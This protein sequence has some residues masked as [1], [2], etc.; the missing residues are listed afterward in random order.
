MKKIPSLLIIVFI[1]SQITV[2][3]QQV[4][5]LNH[6]PPNATSVYEINIPVLTSKVSWQEIIKHFP[7]KKHDAESEEMMQLLS[8]PSLAGIDMN[9]DIIIAKSGNVLF[10]SVT[11]TIIIGYIN[12]AEK[13]SEAIMKVKPASKIIVIPNKYRQL[14]D[15][16]SGM[17]WNDKIFVVVTVQPVWNGRNPFSDSSTMK[18]GGHQKK[19]T[20]IQ[21]DVQAI[22]YSILASKKSIAVFKGFE[23]SFFADD[24][25]FRTDFTNNADVHIWTEQPN[26]LALMKKMNSSNVFSMMQQMN[27]SAGKHS[28]KILVSIRFDNGMIKMDSK[29]IA[30]PM[31]SIYQKLVGRPMSMDL[32]HKIPGEQVIGFFSISFDPTFIIDMLGNGDRRKKIDST[33]DS[34]NLKLDDIVGAFKGDF[35][36][37]AMQPADTDSLH[38]IRI[39]F[40][41][42][43]NDQQS[44]NKLIEELK[45]PSDNKK[46]ENLFSKMKASYNAK[47]NILGLSGNQQMADAFVNNELTNTTT[48]L[49]SE[50]EKSNS[51]NIAIDFKTLNDFLRNSNG[52]FSPKIKPAV[53]L[54]KILDKLTITRGSLENNISETHLELKMIDGSENSLRTL[55]NLIG[56]GK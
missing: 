46:G 40:G 28:N 50:K 30:P 13:F 18:I 15:K 49:L 51:F 22:N 54:I 23:K 41:A 48:D 9:Q 27:D 1:I 7:N 2:N 31:N 55:V 38:K 43:I 14:K 25:N 24:K 19:A 39:Y 8:D 34:K 44:L 53:A 17:C 3:A 33:L 11:Y 4:S 6:I 32:M 12:N 37:M 36:L 5:L 45:K 16:R 10:D 21:P 35:L 29:F 56:G 52:N 26:T 47:E 42:T 20:I